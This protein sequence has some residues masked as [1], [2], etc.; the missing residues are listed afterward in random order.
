MLAILAVDIRGTGDLQKYKEPQQATNEKKKKAKKPPT[1]WSEALGDTITSK[2]GKG[3]NATICSCN[4]KE[5]FLLLLKL[6][7]HLN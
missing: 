3:N 6:S 5:C 2:L 4:P 7:F 1:V